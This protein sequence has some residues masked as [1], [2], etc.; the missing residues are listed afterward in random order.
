MLNWEKH[1]FNMVR[2]LKD[3]YEHPQLGNYLGFKGGT[4]CRLFYGLTRYSVDLDF[5]LIFSEN[6]S[7]KERV[8]K[9]EFIFSEM[10]KILKKYS[11]LEIR[12]ATIKHYTIFFLLSYGK[13]EHTVKVEISRRPN[14]TKFVIEN[15][16]G[17]PMRVTTKEDAFANK[18]IALTDRKKVAMRDVFDVYYFFSE[19]WSIN[20]E[21]VQKKVEMSLRKY[22][23]KCVEFVSSLSD[24]HIL[25]GLGELLDEPQKNWAKDKLKT[26]TIF[27]IKNYG[28]TL[29]K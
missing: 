8:K 14:K 7:E 3:I 21:I 6:L 19:G 27:L 5:D 25:D 17:I 18:L 4:A 12:E 20:E 10:E 1:K 26:E 15:Y 29:R 11:E 13:G 9:E 28:S 23:D 22:L 16:L 2:I 24:N